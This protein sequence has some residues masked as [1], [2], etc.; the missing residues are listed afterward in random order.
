MQ[1]GVS[2]HDVARCVHKG[3]SSLSVDIKFMTVPGVL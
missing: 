1:D 2:N 3:Q